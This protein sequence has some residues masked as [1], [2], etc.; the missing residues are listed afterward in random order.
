MILTENWTLLDDRD[1]AGLVELAVI[2]EQAGVDAVML[3]EHIVLGGNA[4][5]GG[6]PDNP[7]AYAMPGNQQPASAWP[8]SLVVM[9]AIAA[10]TCRV[11]LVGGAII[12]PLRHPLAL[13]KDL[14]T[15]DLLSR[16]RLVVLPTVSWH[17]AEYDALAV[18][19]RSRGRILDEQLEVWKA[20][21]SHSP[22]EYHGRYFD[23]ADIYL[24]PKAHRP[25]GPRLWFGGAQMH[26]NLLRR[27][28]EYGSG[29]NPLGQPSE[30][31]VTR[32]R[33]GMRGAGRDVS[34]LE[35]VGGTRATFEHPDRPADFDRAFAPIARQAEQGFTTFCV[36]PGQFIDSVD[37]YP[38]FCARAV[39]RVHELAG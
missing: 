19:F 17:Q 7:R 28:V 22:A 6:L 34:E 25:G 4:D 31:D 18:P 12:S 32:L 36:K 20:V 38:D 35:F 39:Q 5:A 15:L 21:W 16:G 33:R 13:A 8:S 11:R 37:E 2:A 9:S 1:V 29:Y 14:A 10:R 23:F 26:D 3:S 30:D 27:L 24:E